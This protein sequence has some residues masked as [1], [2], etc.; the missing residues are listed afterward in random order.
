MTDTRANGVRSSE[1]TPRPRNSVASQPQQHDIEQPNIVTEQESSHLYTLLKQGLSISPNDVFNAIC[2]MVAASFMAHLHN[3]SSDDSASVGAICATAYT[4]AR[5]VGSCHQIA[6]LFTMKGITA[7][8]NSDNRIEVNITPAE[9]QQSFIQLIKIGIVDSTLAALFLLSVPSIYRLLG[10]ASHITDVSQDFVNIAAIS[11]YAQILN[12]GLQQTLFK[13][14]KHRQLVQGATIYLTLTLSSLLFFQLVWGPLNDA[15]NI[16]LSFVIGTWGTLAFYLRYLHHRELM[17]SLNS[18]FANLFVDPDSVFTNLFHNGNPIAVQ[19]VSELFA[20]ILMPILATILIDK[21]YITDALAILNFANIINLTAVV[22]SITLAQAGSNLMDS[23]VKVYRNSSDR[24]YLNDIRQIAHTTLRGGLIYNSLIILALVPGAYQIASLFYN[25]Q[26]TD[27]PGVSNNPYILATIIGVG[28]LINSRRDLC[29]FMLRS[30]GIF[31]LAAVS[32]VAT[33]WMVNIPIAIALCKAPLNLNVAAILLG[34]Y[35][36]GI[37]LGALFLRHKL[38]E[39]M[40]LDNLPK[41]LDKNDPEHNTTINK[42]N[43]IFPESWSRFWQPHNP[44]Q[45]HI[46]LLGAVADTN[47]QNTGP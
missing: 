20:V 30:L 23:L 9:L 7:I 13:M 37:P 5:V 24:R 11:L 46:P 28:L 34:Y 1:L 3:L 35:G 16:A 32:S 40:S 8:E 4:V 44:S 45:I 21:K 25:P 12:V 47:N 29:L 33:L 19:L 15:Q 42:I 17:P 10:T 18:F 2:V 31:G 38:N 6:A 43:R 36:V 39:A 14:D 26:E 41:I 27:I 22:P